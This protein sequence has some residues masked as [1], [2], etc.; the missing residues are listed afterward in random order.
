MD[1]LY[2]LHSL[3]ELKSHRY[4]WNTRHGDW[5]L[6]WN[7]E[8]EHIIFEYCVGFCSASFLEYLFNE[9]KI[10]FE[11]SELFYIILL[12]VYICKIFII[13]LS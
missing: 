11:G 12:Y 9:K 6:N 7:R 4:P 2:S 8:I 10:Y 3:G 13:A 1:E 5:S